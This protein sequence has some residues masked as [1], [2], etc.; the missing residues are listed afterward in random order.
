MSYTNENVIALIAKAIKLKKGDIETDI[1]SLD[2]AY[3]LVS[4]QFSQLRAQ[5]LEN[6][7][8]LYSQK[9]TDKNTLELEALSQA[10]QAVQNARDIIVNDDGEPSVIDTLAEMEAQINQELTNFTTA[11]S[12]YEQLLQDARDLIATD[13]G[14]FSEYSD[15]YDSSYTSQTVSGGQSSEEE[16]TAGG[17][18]GFVEDDLII[19]SM[20]VYQ[21]AEGNSYSTMTNLN[22]EFVL[23]AIP[24][25]DITAIGGY[26]QGESDQAEEIGE[27]K[28]NVGLVTVDED[29]NNVYGI[30]PSTTLMSFMMDEG[31]QA[32]QAKE[33]FRSHINDITGVAEGIP[34]SMDIYLP[35]KSIS[36]KLSTLSMASDDAVQAL[37]ARNQ[38]IAINGLLDLTID[39]DE[40]AK[41]VSYSLV[42]RNYKKKEAY[43]S[44]AKTLTNKYSGLGTT[45]NTGASTITI[46]AHSVTSYS[47]NNNPEN[48]FHMAF[49]GNYDSSLIDNVN[50]LATAGSISL[51]TNS[52]YQVK[53]KNKAHLFGDVLNMVKHQSKS[54]KL[55]TIYS[56]PDDRK[57]SYADEYRNHLKTSVSSL[58]KNIGNSSVHTSIIKDN[59]FVNNIRFTYSVSNDGNYNVGYDDYR[60]GNFIT[61]DTL[62]A[63]SKL[64][65]TK[66]LNDHNNK[67]NTI[68][69]DS[70]TNTLIP[71]IVPIT[72]SSPTDIVVNDSLQFRILRE[73]GEIKI[74][75][76]SNVEYLAGSNEYESALKLIYSLSAKYPDTENH[77]LWDDTFA[78]YQ[79]LKYRAK[80]I[81]AFD[82]HF[83]P[84]E[85]YMFNDG[86]LGLSNFRNYTAKELDSN[87]SSTNSRLGY[88]SIVQELD[89]LG[90]DNINVKHTNFI[91]P[92]D[93]LVSEFTLS[94]GVIIK[95]PDSA[96]IEIARTTNNANSQYYTNI[97]FNP[98]I[99]RL[100]NVVINGGVSGVGKR[101]G[102]HHGYTWEEDGQYKFNNISG[103]QNY[104]E[105]SIP[106]IY[107][108]LIGSNVPQLSSEY[109]THENKF[110][111][112]NIL[113]NPVSTTFLER[114]QEE[115]KALDL[116]EFGISQ[117]FKNAFSDLLFKAPQYYHG[118][119]GSFDLIEYP[120]NI[121]NY[122][123]TEV[124][125]GTPELK[126]IIDNF[127]SEFAPL[128][129]SGITQGLNIGIDSYDL[130]SYVRD[131]G[132]LSGLWNEIH[133]MAIDF[134]PHT[135]LLKESNSVIKLMNY[136]ES[137]V[138][139]QLKDYGRGIKR[140]KLNGPHEES[141]R[142]ST[143]F[144]SFDYTY[145]L[146][147]AKI[148]NIF[149]DDLLSEDSD[150]LLG[151]NSRVWANFLFN[152]IT[153]I[154]QR[155]GYL[156][157]RLFQDNQGLKDKLNDFFKSHIYRSNL[158]YDEG[159]G[160]PFKQIFEYLGHQSTEAFLKQLELRYNDPNSIFSTNIE[161]Y[162]YIM[163]LAYYRKLMRQY[164]IHNNDIPAFPH[165][166]QN[167]N[168]YNQLWNVSGT[169]PGMSIQ[170]DNEYVNSILNFEEG[171]KGYADAKAHFDNKRTEILSKID[172]SNY[173]SNTYK[174]EWAKMLL[175]SFEGVLNNGYWREQNNDEFGNYFGHAVLNYERVITPSWWDD[176]L[177]NTYVTATFKDVFLMHKLQ[178][179]IGTG[180]MS[181]NEGWR[182]L[183]NPE[184]VELP[185]NVIPISSNNTYSNIMQLP[186]VFKR[187]YEEVPSTAQ[188]N[189]HNSIIGEDND[190]N[191]ASRVEGLYALGY[192][193][194]SRSTS[195]ET[196]DSYSEDYISSD[197]EETIYQFA[198]QAGSTNIP[199]LIEDFKTLK[200]ELDKRHYFSQSHWMKINPSDSNFLDSFS[201]LKQAAQNLLDK[202]NQLSQSNDVAA[203]KQLLTE[204][205][206]RETRMIDYVL[207]VLVP[208]PV[209]E[210]VVEEVEEG[211]YEGTYEGSGFNG[212][213]TDLL[214]LDDELL[215]EYYYYEDGGFEGIGTDLLE[216]DDTIPNID[217]SQF[218]KSELPG[219]FEQYN[220]AVDVLSNVY[221]PAFLDR[222]AAEANTDMRNPVQINT[223]TFDNEI[224]YSFHV[225]RP[226]SGD[227]YAHPN[228]AQ[229]DA[230][231]IRGI[232]PLY[233]FEAD[234]IAASPIGGATMY[235]A[236]DLEDITGVP[237]ETRYMPAG[238]QKGRDNEIENGTWNNGT[239]Y[240]DGSSQSLINV[241]NLG[242]FEDNR[243]IPMAIEGYY[244]L[245]I[246]PYEAAYS[247]YSSNANGGLGTY[248]SHDINGTKWF[249]PDGL[250]LGENMFHG[251]FGE[252]TNV[253]DSSV[254]ADDSS[255]DADD[256]DTITEDTTYYYYEYSD[257]SGIGVGL[258]DINGNGE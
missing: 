150:R 105:S 48:T 9:E 211:T 82:T 144:G 240:F 18:I 230:Q 78:L 157:N 120:N 187:F 112:P 258:L 205:V 214:D 246:T 166:Y 102:S 33:G 129:G 191:N 1:S 225:S 85:P 170:V 24:V 122:T 134:A 36:K 193:L 67:L 63:E 130:N 227:N 163:N 190:F 186:Y 100:F 219:G 257:F 32:Q 106:S 123:F 118:G 101:I 111:N 21:D 132:Y 72:L 237:F 66:I 139:Y 29:G 71:V 242:A 180:I 44:L 147:D 133:Q 14:A 90:Y 62:N 96:Y 252:V 220:L 177:T 236:T 23:E 216:T 126:T 238:L 137:N 151:N 4:S 42:Q 217:W 103:L 70:V 89:Q 131:E 17:G 12:N 221:F 158:M 110:I 127:I 41:S 2:D 26:Q 83:N 254:D 194:Q 91:N 248:H 7:E 75:S 159:N 37:A 231:C 243:E 142:I 80:S 114:L 109:D 201:E 86:V 182:F 204:L 244:P 234:A 200:S 247:N 181:S 61:N 145:N 143:I 229:D 183:Y 25:G 39:Y 88:N 192:W 3:K 233:T 168:T 207:P 13:F 10:L 115:L 184:V 174:K 210:E 69:N 222:D 93:N 94:N 172:S 31:L 64:N 19:N 108:S 239:Y 95:N 160:I 189:S 92:Y 141:L 156:T 87:L 65:S 206:L 121:N 196:F 55:S 99:G 164:S 107:E 255:V 60:L 57:L 195:F 15:S 51:R 165:S 198:N 119:N 128:T 153:N 135:N 97:N 16:A 68:Y 116:S 47:T 208:K 45:V 256:S 226:T 113:P 149:A 232:Y 173:H 117:N 56:N 241:I 84:S 253:V 162:E 140:E 209:V 235:S 245:F 161:I 34:T 8:T 98:V 213:G 223:K 175:P 40:S 250:T 52:N 81:E 11:K 74:K 146:A 125:D 138:Y 104:I 43:K 76:L 27:L 185:N 171:A 49:L 228:G 35:K 218:P 58:V 124:N 167:N 212:I 136:V 224:I 79:N 38:N 46:P 20:I 251:N 59:A 6:F 22:G 179:E 30:T 215:A 154:Y 53:E 73:G 188:G 77:P 203:V 202:V 178:A 169:T 199:A 28:I 249:M 176:K 50:V 152:S 54:F 197:I 5:A 155:V 148:V